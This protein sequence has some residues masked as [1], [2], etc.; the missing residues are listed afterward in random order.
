MRSV[1]V[2]KPPWKNC[3]LSW[4]AVPRPKEYLAVEMTA[5]VWHRLAKQNS[6]G[7]SRSLL[8]FTRTN[9][10][11]LTDTTCFYLKEIKVYTEVNNGTIPKN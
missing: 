7:N 6:E 9:V 1:H 11:P 3:F 4:N 2:N 5:D 10:K 8:F